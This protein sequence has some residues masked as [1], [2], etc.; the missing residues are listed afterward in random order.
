MFLDRVIHFGR[1]GKG[2]F[3]EK[4][5]IFDRGSLCSEPESTGCKLQYELYLFSVACSQTEI[6][7]GENLADRV[8][9]RLP[10]KQKSLIEVLYVLHV[11]EHVLSL[12][13]ILISSPQ[14][15]PRLSHTFRKIFGGSGKGS[16][17]E[18]AGRVDRGSICSALESTGCKLES[19]P[20]LFSVECS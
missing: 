4:D 17:P 18:R 16:F 19:E 7:F 13:M 2:S 20:C 14:S 5:K 3:T 15:V 9:G 8:K 10:K 1:S 11:K 12:N 6:H